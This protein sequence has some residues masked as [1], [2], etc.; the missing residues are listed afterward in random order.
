MKTI[1]TLFLI[2]FA[3]I[4]Y[5]QTTII[6]LTQEQ[7]QI[8][9]E[10]AKKQSFTASG[11]KTTLITAEGSTLFANLKK[12]NEM[13][14]Y[15]LLA[16]PNPA[17]NQITVQVPGIQEFFMAEIFDISGKL[18]YQKQLQNPTNHISIKEIP[19]GLYILKA[20]TANQLIGVKRIIIN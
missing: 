19:S 15:Q 2:A 16:Y 11:G 18:V 10:V 9:Y 13:P 20:R 3:F 14:L 1:I 17:Q 8:H 7:N 12:E 4:G 5:S 6:E